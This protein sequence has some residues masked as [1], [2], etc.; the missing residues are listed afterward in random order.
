MA[1]N[2][3]HS[4]SNTTTTGKSTDDL[5][6]IDIPFSTINSSVDSKI[7]PYSLINSVNVSTTATK[8]PT[9]VLKVGSLEIVLSSKTG[10]D[11]DIISI[12]SNDGINYKSAESASG[13][14]ASYVRSKT[15]DA[16]HIVCSGKSYLKIECFFTAAYNQQ[17]TNNLTITWN[18]NEPRAI[19]SVSK[20]GEGTVTGAGT[21]HY[22]K[23]Y[24]ISAT[25]A[26]GWKFV[27]WSDGNANASRT[28]TVDSSI[29]TAYETSKS[30]QAIFEKQSYAVSTSVS[31][32]GSG[33][34]TGGGTYEFGSTATLTATPATGYKFVKWN[35]NVTTATRT[36]TVS[37]AATYTAYFEKIKVTATFVNHDGTTL[38]TVAVDYGTTPSYTGSTPTKSSTA[39]YSYS[40][41][42]WSP[43]LGNITTATT[44]IAQFTA[45]KRK[46]TLTVT[47]GTGGSVSGGGT[48]EYGTKPTL[49]ATP[50]SG[51]KFVKW[52]DG[53]TTASRTVTVTGNATYTAEF[54]LDKINNINV[55][56]VKP[57]AIYYDEH[58]IVFVVDGTIPTPATSIFD[59]VDGYHIKVQNTVPSGMTEVKEVY[60]DTVKVYG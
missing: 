25:P 4:Y 41:S 23:T 20:S 14:L 13:S 9:G 40:F 38:Q 29:I 44:Y 37:T 10:T 31:P 50:A 3:T 46:Y 11:N 24:T 45:T 49:T 43:T 30:Y 60:R 1:D 8:N 18:Y 27:K 53:V 34:V 56:E 17:F 48:Y 2:L 59:T 42:G 57:K 33:S 51:Y 6:C 36:V 12:A 16:G 5:H 32:S 58:N 54:E 55:D 52:S 19:V 15:S 47:A 22:G 35:D 39:E 28:F 26:T 21:Y 7:P